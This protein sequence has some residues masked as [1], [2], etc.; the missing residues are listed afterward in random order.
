MC[1]STAR[2]GSMIAPQILLLAIIWPPLPSL[3]LVIL[4]ILNLA[5]AFFWLPE[6]K[7]R[8][9][10]DMSGDTTDVEEKPPMKLSISEA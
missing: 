9:L 1:N 3:L 4:A 8:P 5:V 10:P 2:I 6:T 7:G